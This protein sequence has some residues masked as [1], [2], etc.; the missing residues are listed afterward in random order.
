[1]VISDD[2]SGSP[3]STPPR[4]PA[5]RPAEPKVGEH[6]F[7]LVDYKPRALSRRTRR[8]IAAALAR[9][10]EDD[11]EL[12]EVWEDRARLVAA[13]QTPPHIL[14][15]G[16]N[17]LM[18]HSGIN[19]IEPEAWKT[20]E[21]H[22]SVVELIAAGHMEV[23]KELP[24]RELEA[25]ADRTWSVAGLDAIAAAEKGFSGDK[26]RQVVVDAIGTQR[27]QVI[28]HRTKPEPKKPAE[29]KAPVR[30]RRQLQRPRR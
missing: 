7:V 15:L 11:P 14:G 25:L 5:S 23:L 28:K 3:G 13:N 20:F 22:P 26:P 2:T 1:M 18:L 29:P 6:K 8:E 4:R 12:N 16:E 21:S 24:R 17:T 19:P 10:K 27:A 30:P 9:L